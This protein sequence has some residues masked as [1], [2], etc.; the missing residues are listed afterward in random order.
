MKWEDIGHDN[1]FYLRRAR[2]F[3]GWLVNAIAD[4]N[5]LRHDGYSLST[6]QGYEWRNSITFVPDPNHEWDL[7]KTY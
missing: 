1:G 6:S 7:D 5:T 4:V 2:I 3:G